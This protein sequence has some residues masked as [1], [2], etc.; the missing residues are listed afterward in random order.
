[1]ILLDQPDLQAPPQHQI[2]GSPRPINPP[3]KDERIEGIR[4][5]PLNRQAPRV[6]IDR[7]SHFY[8]LWLLKKPQPEIL[9]PRAMPVPRLKITSPRHLNRLRIGK[10]HPEPRFFRRGGRAQI[11]LRAYRSNRVAVA[12]RRPMNGHD[13]VASILAADEGTILVDC[14]TLWLSN[15]M[16]AGADMD[17]EINAL[18][19]SLEHSYWKAPNSQNPFCPPRHPEKRP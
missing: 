5:Q 9:I 7:R 11:A 10:R 16:L 1:M 8:I 19:V 6:R 15:R 3:A 13:D 14:L 2:A 4:P 12:P 17:A 18:E